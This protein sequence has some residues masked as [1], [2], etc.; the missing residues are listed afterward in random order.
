MNNINRLKALRDLRAKQKATNVK[1]EDVF[2]T[3]DKSDAMID[4]N[5]IDNNAPKGPA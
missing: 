3:Q 2:M 1:A 5:A 4:W